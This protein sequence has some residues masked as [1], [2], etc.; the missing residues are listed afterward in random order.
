MS[1]ISNKKE[2]ETPAVQPAAAEKPDLSGLKESADKARAQKVP[3]L[4][5]PT[6]FLSPEGAAFITSLVTAAVKEAVA[7]VAL[8]PEKL[9]QMEELR[10]APSAEQKAAEAREKR[11]RA[12]LAADLADQQKNKEALQ[13]TC[14]HKYP[15]GGWAISIVHNFP[16]RAPRGF[17]HL[18]SLWI[19]P[20]QWVIL[21]P[22]AENPRGKPVIQ[23]AHP[24]YGVVL[25]IE[26]LR[27]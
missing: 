9:Q 16:D 13:A 24:L 3:A 4:P 25:E 22:D 27:S 20:R 8:T 21:A 11:E 2:T 26:R 10:R 12:N 1:T 23:P 15:T 18:C 17:C 19:A 14:G 5:V 7:N 6:E